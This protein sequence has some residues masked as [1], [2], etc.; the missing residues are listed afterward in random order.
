MVTVQHHSDVSFDSSAAWAD[1]L[2][3]AQL[4]GDSE[5]FFPRGTYHFYSGTKLQHCF[6]SNNDESVKQIVFHLCFQ[7]DLKLRGDDAK[8]IFHGRL[9]PFVL[10]ECRNISISGISIDFATPFHFESELLES[11]GKSSLLRIPGNW[12]IENGKFLVFNDGLDALS[13]KV[14]FTA[15]NRESGEIADL[16]G[17]HV[18]NRDLICEKEHELL[19]VPV[20]MKTD[21]PNLILRHQA[22]HTPAFLIDKSEDILIEHITVHHAEGMAVVGQ[23]SRN[24]LLDHISVVPSEGRDLSVT[25]DAVHFSECEGRIEIRNS[26]FHQTLDDAVNVHGMYRRLKR[27]G[28]YLLLEACHFQQFGLWNGKPGDILELV[29]AETMQAYARIRCKGFQPGTKQLYCLELAEPLP[30]EYE[31]GDIARVL[32]S[33]DMEVIV[34][35]NDMANNMSRGILL[36]GAKRGLIENNRIHSPGNGI[37]ISGDANYW[38]ES[39][40]VRELEI[41]G[42]TFDYC[43][44]LQ[45]DAVPVNID[46]VIPRKEPGF[47][48]HGT[49]KVHDNCFRIKD[50]SPVLKAHSVSELEFSGNTIESVSSPETE[51][52]Q[53][54]ECGKIT[55]T[56]NLFNGK[57]R[58]IRQFQLEK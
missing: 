3:T 57:M 21:Q 12:T 43:A 45:K 23:N 19:R 32:R 38:Y 40:P 2:K 27:S 15:Y 28:E 44:Y 17:Y 52:L 24:I 13:G 7:K 36:S 22:R 29:K 6:I 56:G 35:G 39:G 26:T 34:S 20:G 16:C 53:T 31:N 1:A 48:Y 18:P 9:L 10:E 4:N 54:S 30:P 46:P 33:A 11:D 58:K 37:Y 51:I 8:F 41:R 5:I 25:D 50:P 49:V 14:I 55:G 42:N 47:F